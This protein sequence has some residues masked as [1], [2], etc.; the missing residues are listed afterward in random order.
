MT[1]TT[2]VMQTLF[3]WIY[4]LGFFR[5]D[6]SVLPDLCIHLVLFVARLFSRIYPLVIVSDKAIFLDLF[7]RLG[8]GLFSLGFVSGKAFSRIFTIGFDEYKIDNIITP[9]FSKERRNFLTQNGNKVATITGISCDNLFTWN[10]RSL[11]RYIVATCEDIKAFFGLSEK[12]HFYDFVTFL[13]CLHT[14]FQQIKQIKNQ[15]LKCY[16]L[17]PFIKKMI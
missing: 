5:C 2:Y 1:S 12:G 16:F 11:C 9:G 15:L 7:T 8:Q 6:K 3:S 4:S 14:S 17:Y 13:W 10:F